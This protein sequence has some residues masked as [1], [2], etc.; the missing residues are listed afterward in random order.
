[1]NERSLLKML[2]GVDRP[3]PPRPEFVRS[4]GAELFGASDPAEAPPSLATDRSR[5]GEGVEAV[6]LEIVRPRVA[7][8]PTRRRVALVAIA[9][10][11]AAALGAIVVLAHRGAE[12]RTLAVSKTTVEQACQ[13]F[14]VNAFNGVT[15]T[16]LLGNFNNQA[17]ADTSTARARTQNLLAA[18]RVFSTDLEH[19]G[20]RDQE[21]LGTIATAEGFA[22]RALAAIDQNS[23]VTAADNLKEIG[24]RLD[25]VQR[26]L[27]TV[28]VAKCL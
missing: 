7:N 13:R 1:M 23:L 9:M 11:I 25:E 12:P 27:I 21:T 5:D 2:K 17:L 16:Q 4:L 26:D 28:G 6:D 15:K 22:T 8:R 10:S 18:L 19:A 3:R 24:T 20:V 14:N